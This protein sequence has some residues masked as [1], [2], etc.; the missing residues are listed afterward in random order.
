MILFMY[1]FST[2]FKLDFFLF[3]PINCVYI[4]IFKNEKLMKTAWIRF[5]AIFKKK[6]SSLRLL[7]ILRM[8][9]AAKP[10]ISSM[11]NVPK[12]SSFYCVSVIV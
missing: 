2:V 6:L 3:K 11:L 5:Q 12:C 10:A 1:G 4:Y 8:S 7:H 9:E